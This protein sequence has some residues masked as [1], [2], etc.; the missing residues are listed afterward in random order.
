VE[1]LQSWASQKRSE[2]QRLEAPLPAQILTTVD[3]SRRNRQPNSQYSRN[4]FILPLHT[5]LQYTLSTRDHLTCEFIIFCKKKK[6][7]TTMN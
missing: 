3:Q 7:D 2:L 1:L 5:D 4:L 6:R